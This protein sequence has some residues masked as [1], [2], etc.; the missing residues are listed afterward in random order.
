MHTVELTLKDRAAFVY[1]R[2]LI[3]QRLFQPPGD[4]DDG[5]WIGS[6]DKARDSAL[7]AG[8]RELLDELT[9]H[10]KLLTTVPFPLSEWRPGDGPDDERW[11]A[12]TEIERRDVLAL[13]SGYENLI[14]WGE[15]ITNDATGLSDSTDAVAGTAVAGLRLASPHTRRDVLDY[16]KAERTRVGRFRQEMC[17]LERRRVAD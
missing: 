12:L 4:S 14:A 3:L 5:D 1:R 8:I 2:L 7:C 11:R 9:E 10:A 17:F 15:A 13:V 6:G 16:L